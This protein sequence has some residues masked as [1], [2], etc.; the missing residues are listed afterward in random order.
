[1]AWEVVALTVGA[2]CWSK[3]AMQMV[4]HTGGGMGQGGL[5][6]M[7]GPQTQRTYQGSVRLM[8]VEC[9]ISAASVSCSQALPCSCFETDLH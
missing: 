8:H 5:E 9:N 3:G 6:A 1:M 7:T 2:Q 4:K